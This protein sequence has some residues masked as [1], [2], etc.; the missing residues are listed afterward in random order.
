MKPSDILE[1]G[2]IYYYIRYYSPNHIQSGLDFEIVK[3]KVSKMLVWG[4]AY[5]PLYGYTLNAYYSFENYFQFDG[6]EWATY[7]CPS[8]TKYC[9]ED[10]NLICLGPGIFISKDK[11][12]IQRSLRRA[13]KHEKDWTCKLKKYYKE[14]LYHLKKF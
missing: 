3:F 2:G 1:E 13:V 12:S 10:I 7:I 6:R 4:I 14:A 9:E 11:L 8:Y 5:K